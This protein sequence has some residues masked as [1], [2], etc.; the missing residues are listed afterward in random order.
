[1]KQILL[2]ILAVACFVLCAPPAYGCSCVMP[3]VPD[4]LKT[5]KAVF[6]GEVVEIVE[7]KT[8]N[9]T[10]PLP[11]RFFTIKFKIE[12]SWKGVPFAAREFNVL[13]AQG[14]YGCFA[15]PPVSK[16]QRYLVY[17]DAASDI[18]N[19]GLITMCNRTTVVR[20]GSNPRILNPDAIDP[21]WDIKQLDAITKRTFTFDSARS[22]RR[23]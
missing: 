11:G 19:W 21:Y 23:V 5:A 4:A 8:T 14:R 6:L 3:E 10:A 17:A 16:G 9:E 13:S 22:R 12:K 18:G 2:S 15:F 20:L 1:M 7:P